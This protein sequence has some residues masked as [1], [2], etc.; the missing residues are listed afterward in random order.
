MH[1]ARLRIEHGERA[2]EAT[3]DAEHLDV[4]AA[5]LP[6]LI[7]E[8]DDERI[9]ERLFL[10]QQLSALV[11]A[12]AGAFLAVRTGSGWGRKVVPGLKAWMREAR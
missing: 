11:D 1:Q 8:E 9:L 4:R 12:L 7:A 10:A 2:W 3:L 5:R 6:E